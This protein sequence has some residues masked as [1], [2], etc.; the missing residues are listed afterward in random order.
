MARKAQL[1]RERRDVLRVRELDQR[2]TEAQPTLIARDRHALVAPENISEVC[3]GD[4]ELRGDAGE[5]SGLAS[6]T[7]EFFGGTDE[8]GA[9]PP[10]LPPRCGGRSRVH[11]ARQELDD[12]LFDLDIV[13]AQANI[14]QRRCR[15]LQSRRRTR[16]RCLARQLREARRG[17]FAEHRRHRIDM[18]RDQHVV[19]RLI[20]EKSIAAHVARRDEQRMICRQQRV[21]RTALVDERTAQRQHDLRLRRQRFR[22]PAISRSSRSRAFDQHGGVVE[23]T[24][25]RFLIGL[26]HAPILIRR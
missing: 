7:D 6:G 5:R 16:D 10:C 19:E 13:I 2:A 26:Q 1:Q 3:R 8:P 18:R 17:C 14:P 12:R 20:V 22:R 21:R 15:A 24:T 25:A 9:P 23:E 4:V 11:D